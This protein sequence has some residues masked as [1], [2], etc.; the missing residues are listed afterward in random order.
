MKKLLLV[1]VLA[2][3]IVS[4]NVAPAQAWS[5]NGHMIIAA[6]TYRALPDTLKIKYTDMLRWHPDFPQWER[7]HELL[8]VK[9]ELGEYLFMQASVWPDAIRRKGN[10]YDHP[11]WHYTNFP[12]M[13]DNFLMEETLTPENDV[14][15][16]IQES[17]RV[18]ADRNHSVSAVDKAAHLSWIL[19]T[20]GDL[21]QPLH[22]VALVNATFPE[23]DRGGN[24]FYVRPRASSRGVNLHAYWDG[25]LGTS[26]RVRDARNDATR[27]WASLAGDLFQTV[28]ED[29]DVRGWALEG[30]AVA[31]E[32]VYLSGTLK[33]TVEELRSAAAILPETYGQRAKLIAQER[34]VIA[35]LRLLHVL[36]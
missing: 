23:G 3:G 8:T 25:L 15:F 6:M 1:I 36:S 29:F 28:P 14:I 33:E 30:R 11:T 22:C 34:A 27:I 19:H 20:I 16:A 17:R 4:T 9:M 12:L 13:P 21:H 5:K 35:S 31:I 24:L 32:D 26:G 10:E 18:L 7:E 2:F